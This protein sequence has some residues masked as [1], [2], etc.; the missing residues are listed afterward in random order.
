VMNLQRQLS[1]RRPLLRRRMF[2][3]KRKRLWFPPLRFQAQA[4]GA[5][6]EVVGEEGPAALAVVVEEQLPRADPQED[7]Q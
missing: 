2:R 4:A 3:R 1:R 7:A 6:G 5:V